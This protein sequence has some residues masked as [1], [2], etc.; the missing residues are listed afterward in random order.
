MLTLRAV[1]ARA[2]SSLSLFGLWALTVLGC[3]LA[4]GLGSAAH[5]PTGSALG[6]VLLGLV[7]LAAHCATSIR[8]R[9]PEVALA[10]LRGVR[11]GRLLRAAVSEPAAVLAAA[12]ILGSALA[13]A[14]GPILARRWTGTASAFHLGAEGWATTAVLLAAGLAVVVAVSWRTMYQPLYDLIDAHR[15]PRAV[16][17]AGSFL[18]L[19]A[20]FG[21]AASTYQAR[22]LGA[23]RA[24]WLSFLSPALIGLTA[25]QLAI[26][27]LALCCRA[28]QRSPRLD[29]R[30]P[31]FLTVRRLSRR[32]GAVAAVRLVVAGVVIA[33]VATMSWVGSRA[34]S[35]STARIE[36]G[37]PI[38][39]D[40]PT[41]ALQAYTA[42][43]RADPAGRWLMA[44]SASA[45]PE[46]GSARALFVDTTR[47]R[48]VVG[49]FFAG[50]PVDDVTRSL[51][52][53][54]PGTP[55]T[56][57]RAATASVRF[58]ALSARR[59]L[60]SSRQLGR[61]RQ[62]LLRY[63]IIPLQFT[64]DY[65]D[66]RGEAET[67]S[68]PPQ[69]WRAPVRLGRGVVGYTVPVPHCSRACAVGDVSVQGRT[70]GRL[71]MTSLTFGRLRLLH[72][73]DQGLSPVTGKHAA[74]TV[75]PRRGGLDLEVTDPF[76]LHPLLRFAPR[77]A[78]A[79]ATPGLRLSIVRGRP[80]ADGIDGASRPVRVDGRTRA[81]PLLGRE[82]VLL[83]LGAALRGAGGQIPD[84]ASLVVARS[85]TPAAVL[86]RLEATGAVGT[87]RM[88][89]AVL[90][91][92][93]AD[94]AAVGVRL[95]LLLAI[96]GLLVCAVSVLASVAEQRRERRGEAAALRSAGVRAASL[97]RSY[98]EEAAWL[99]AAVAVA[100]LVAAEAG[101]RAVLAVLPLVRS[102]RFELGFDS[103][104]RF[105]V[106]AGVAVGAG[107]FVAAA[108]F[109]ALRLV[110]ASSPPDRLRE[111]AR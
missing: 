87:K 13:A 54:A 89:G 96:L 17:T 4:V 100:G 66:D 22:Q 107:T 97:A 106:L 72:P 15:R 90:E 43:R 64:I 77:Q 104:P 65:V 78:A 59:T 39:Y 20:V 49:D 16:G 108:V 94:D 56:A 95:Y 80:Q 102:G 111:E 53:I 50:T 12:T 51:G 40:V 33:G 48:R 109:L 35:D 1:A 58:T 27:L 84:T 61:V 37:G 71:R 91:R 75:V 63:D 93:E 46:G 31:S 7:A 68:L 30:L 44:E 5:L 11:G 70:H 69:P 81:L 85:D 105:G 3:V 9:S 14:G 98:L 29:A 92:I 57:V 86:Q 110:A 26:W 103:T 41:G 74:T 60:P 25:G 47:W 73:V 83:D 45:G 34:W 24:D 67:V 42:S 76:D 21:A 23:G 79:I 19:L 28:V 88:V 55:A 2:G 101:C 38:A 82:G 99:G 32:A 8:S 36:T 52:A 10:R 18:V 6:L 62:R